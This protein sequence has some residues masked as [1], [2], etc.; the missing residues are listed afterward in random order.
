MP[1]PK[2]AQPEAE[3][4]V[5]A[6]PEAAV[7]A[8]PVAEEVVVEE[9]AAP[10]VAEEA[11]VEEI[12]PQLGDM[13]DEGAEYMLALRGDPVSQTALLST[14]IQTL[15]LGSRLLD[16]RERFSTKERPFAGWRSF[17]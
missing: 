4:A 8:A 10:A 1:A 13:E 14:S 2:A 17:A 11:V 15:M 6:A 16:P 3:V 5:E 7:V 12:S 9:A